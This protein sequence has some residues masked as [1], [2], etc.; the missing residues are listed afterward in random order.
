MSN[1]LKPDAA[2]LLEIY[3]KAALIKRNDDYV[4][5]QMMAGRLVTSTSQ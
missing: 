5:K 1:Y 3:K 4:V 2:T